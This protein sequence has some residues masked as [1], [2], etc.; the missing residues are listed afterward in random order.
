MAAHAQDSGHVGRSL[1][2]REEPRARTEPSG[3]PLKGPQEKEEREGRP[4]RGLSAKVER[5]EFSGNKSIPSDELRALVAHLEG[6]ELSIQQIKRAA[7]LITK[8]YQDRGFPLA[9]AY[10]PPQRVKDGVVHIRVVEGRVGRIVIQG[11]KTYSRRFILDHVKPIWEDPTLDL[12]RLERSLLILNDYPGLSVQATMRRGQKKGTTDLYLT[13]RDEFPIF[14]SIDYDNFGPPNVSEHRVGSTLEIGNL[15][16]AAHSL[17]LRA[18]GGSDAGDVTYGQII[19]T[20]PFASGLK[21]SGYASAYDYEAVGPFAS[22]DPLGDGQTAGLLLSYPLVRHLDFTLELEA[23]LEGKNVE[24]E[25]LGSVTAKDRIRAALVGL[26]LDWPGH[27]GG[28][29]IFHLQMRRGL[30]G[31]AGGLDDKDAGTSRPDADP[32]FNRIVFTGYRL[33]KVNRYLFW[34]TRVQLQATGEPLYASEQFPLGGGDSVR[35]YP[36]FEFIGDKGYA[37]T[38]ELRGRLPFLEGTGFFRIFQLAAFYDVG[39]AI[40]EDP[41]AGVDEKQVLAGWGVGIRLEVPEYGT[42]R[43]DVGWPL[44]DPEPSTGD[45]RIVYVA[46]RFYLK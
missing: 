17:K 37:A 7:D 11:N 23:G 34:V 45:D 6:K 33:Q 1:E 25:M 14:A 5:F 32:S 46:A 2:E 21:L 8:Y 18:V 19:Y 43:V 30:A 20:I 4:D 29:W 12:D 28:H 31:F 13:A 15:F 16:H 22:L 24:Q 3:S 9:W 38:F 35:G 41:G 36:S 39:E 10:V 42:L 40:V 27:W 44:S 26:K